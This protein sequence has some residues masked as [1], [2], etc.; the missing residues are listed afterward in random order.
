MP[1]WSQVGTNMG[2]K[3]DVNFESR[4]YQKIKRKTSFFEIQ[5]VEVRSK[6]G[7]KMHEKFESMMG[8]IL[9]SIFQRCWWIFGAKLGVKIDPESIQKRMEK[10]CKK[11]AARW[12]KNRYKN[13]QVVAGEAVQ[14][15]GEVYHFKQ[16]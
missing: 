15:A 8:C 4:F 7:A 12:Q 1:K 10:R 11:E 9:A 3:I 13:P 14:G 16:G 6:S 5:W 2:S